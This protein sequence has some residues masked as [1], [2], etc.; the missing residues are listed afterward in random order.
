MEDKLVYVIH[1][2]NVNDPEGEPD[3]LIYDN[4]EAAL[5]CKKFLIAQPNISMSCT[6]ILVAS[7]FSVEDDID[8]RIL[9]YGE[10]KNERSKDS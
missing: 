10:K 8:T 1:Y 7:S 9:H 3:T 4:E 2:W 6:T 5:E